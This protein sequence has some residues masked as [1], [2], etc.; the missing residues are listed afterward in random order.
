MQ[1]IKAKKSP[2]IKTDF[3]RWLLLCTMTIVLFGLVMVISASLPLAER[4]QVPTFYFAKNQG[5]YILLGL[6]LAFITTKIPIA[7]LQKCSNYILIFS[8]LLLI[9]ILFPGIAKPI[10]GSVRWLRL[11]FITIQPSE[12]AKLSLIIYIAGYMVRR[13]DKLIT[14]QGF[15]NPMLVL[16]TVA[17]L[18]MLEPDFGSV[19]VIAMTTLGMLY[20]GGVQSKH[21][22]ILLPLCLCVVLFMALSS[23]YRVQ[24]IISFRDPWANQYDSGYQLV[25]SLIAFGKGSWFGQ[26]L[27]SSVQKLLYLPES[28]SDFILAVVAEEL[29]LVGVVSLLALYAF[30]CYRAMNIGKNAYFRDAKFAGNLAYGIG[31]FITIQALINFGVNIGLLPTKGLTLPLMSAG[32]SSM[33]VVL[34]AIGVLFRIDFENRIAQS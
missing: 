31:L 7:F 32:G 14:L 27:G 34:V 6:C 12:I 17:L 28:H 16:A 29:G 18:L 33:L 1:N 4:I 22:L 13:F 25:Q 23:S 11:G 21:F 19:V 9:I 15:I 10:N 3:D 2:A 8:M 26:G 5:L 24:R 30:F 20:L